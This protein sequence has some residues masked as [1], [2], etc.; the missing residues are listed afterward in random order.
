[1]NSKMLLEKA[2]RLY[3]HLNAEYESMPKSFRRRIFVEQQSDPEW[4][5]IEKILP[6]NDE[7]LNWVILI[8][9]LQLFW[10]RRWKAQHMN[11]LIACS[12]MEENE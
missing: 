6:E 11:E 4:Q 10:V 2:D 1:M 3:E 5:R 12:E 7:N 8:E 9:G